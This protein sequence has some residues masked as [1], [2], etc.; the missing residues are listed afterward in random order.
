MNEETEINNTISKR[1]RI[2]VISKIY[3]E[4][5]EYF[6]DDSILISSSFIRNGSA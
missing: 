4:T 3:N 2:G 1:F 6:D 5:V